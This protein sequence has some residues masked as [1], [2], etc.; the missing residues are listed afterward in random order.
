[1]EN[2]N[3]R[4]CT[5]AL[6]PKNDMRLAIG[7]KLVDSTCVNALGDEEGEAVL[8]LLMEDPDEN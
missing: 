4:L 8:G 6:L 3:L 2:L 7:G 1:L 5:I